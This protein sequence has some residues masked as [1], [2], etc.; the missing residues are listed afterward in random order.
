MISVEMPGV[1]APVIR[2]H[3]M[4]EMSL[5]STLFDLE[6]D[7]VLGA[8][9]SSTRLQHHLSAVQQRLTPLLQSSEISELRLARDVRWLSQATYRE[10]GRRDA[11]VLASKLVNI[12][13]TVAVRTAMGGGPG[14]DC[15]HNLH[16]EF[17]IVAER[18]QETIIDCHF[19]DQFRIGQHTQQYQWILN[20]LPEVFVGSATRLAPLVE[21][22]CS[23]MAH[24]FKECS[25]TCPP[26]RHPRSMISKWLPTKAQDTLIGRSNGVTNQARSSRSDSVSSD[27][28]VDDLTDSGLS[29]T[30]PLPSY[31]D[32]WVGPKSWGK[33]SQPFVTLTGF[34]VK[35]LLSSGLAAI[36]SKKPDQEQS[37]WQQP[38]IRT[39]RMTGRPLMQA[40]VA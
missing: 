37:T 26:W 1:R 28:E 16:H 27:D 3:P 39:V 24:A 34:K 30:G 22:L 32:D 13:Y 6:M 10:D 17:L 36:N 14:Q 7:E 31:H 12:G 19:K 18:H 4:K 15:F 29:P 21:L 2:D 8:E 5:T 11:V 25:V 9:V 23:E 33:D 20:G 35:S 40:Q 38:A